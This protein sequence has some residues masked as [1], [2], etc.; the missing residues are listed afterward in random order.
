MARQA[1]CFTL[2]PYYEQSEI[3]K[4]EIILIEV[5]GA[6]SDDRVIMVEYTTSLTVDLVVHAKDWRVQARMCSFKTP[7]VNFTVHS[8]AIE[9]VEGC[10][11]DILNA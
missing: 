7:C 9:E 3:S 4:V 5:V 8:Q 1:R 2:V 11:P 10:L 6:K